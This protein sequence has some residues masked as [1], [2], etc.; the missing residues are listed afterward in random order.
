MISSSM[1]Q[2]SYEWSGKYRRMIIGILRCFNSFIAIC[3]GSV[4]FSNSTIIGAHMA[5]C[6]ARVP[7]TR[8]RSYLKMHDFIPNYQILRQIPWN[9]ERI[10]FSHHNQN[11]SANFYLR[12]KVI[13]HTYFVI[14]LVVM[15][16][17]FGTPPPCCPGAMI[18]KFSTSSS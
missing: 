10:L 11:V 6:K 9:C 2:S 12:F 16:L 8:A 1:L 3:S 4:S 13:Q 7:K 18:S 14:Y 17:F 15:R 5:I